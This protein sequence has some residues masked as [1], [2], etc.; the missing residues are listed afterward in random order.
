MT[1][2]QRSYNLPK[3]FKHAFAGLWHVLRTQR[4]AWIHSLATAAVIVMAF[5]M[6]VDRREWALLLLAIGLVWIAELFNTALE[7]TIDLTKPEPHPLAR[8]GKDIAAAAV[9]I[10]AVFAVIIGIL[11][12][13]PPIW[14]RLTQG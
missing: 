3:A 14:A 5:W 2:P 10:A 8:T 6:R 13:G 7:A 12:L 1:S 4:N 9:L 11:I